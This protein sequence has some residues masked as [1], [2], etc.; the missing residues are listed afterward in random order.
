M[1]TYV[2]SMTGSIFQSMEILSVYHLARYKSPVHITMETMTGT[3]VAGIEEAEVAVIAVIE[4][5]R[6]GEME[7]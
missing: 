6:V 3:E 4:I 5:V 1:N 7:M 2:L